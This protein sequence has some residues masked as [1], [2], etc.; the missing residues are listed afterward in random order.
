MESNLTLV[1]PDIL[2]FAEVQE[3]A[4]CLF[5]A[6]YDLCDDRQT[7]FHSIGMPETAVKRAR[8]RVPWNWEQ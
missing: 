2:Q 1:S 3:V 5:S 7:S 6:I 4:N 8:F